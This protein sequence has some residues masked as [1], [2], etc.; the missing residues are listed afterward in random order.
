MYSRF[1]NLPLTYRTLDFSRCPSYWELHETLRREL[2]LPDWYGRNW[3]ALW[4]SVTGIMAVPADITIVFH[5]QTKAAESLRSDV[6]KVVEIF[7]DALQ[8]YD[9]I[10]LHVDM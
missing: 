5:P 7:Q 9:M 2:E 3:D 1:Q 10:L 8:K 4:D 6:E